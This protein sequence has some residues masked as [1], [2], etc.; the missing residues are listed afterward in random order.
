M[1]WK[2]ARF[3]QFHI[4]YSISGIL[5]S[6]G[7]LPHPSC[8]NRPIKSIRNGFRLTHVPP[9]IFQHVFPA[10]DPK[11]L[12]PPIDR[13]WKR[14]AKV[15]EM[16]RFFDHENRSETKSTRIESWD[17]FSLLIFIISK[18]EMENCWNTVWHASEY[19]MSARIRRSSRELDH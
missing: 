13:Y 6:S 5:V 11:F 10:R 19:E 12:S 16:I 3:L 15:K 7:S 17:A 9:G 4:L 2:G 14:A 8:E 1:R 18:R